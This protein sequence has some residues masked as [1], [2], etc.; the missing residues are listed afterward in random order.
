MTFTPTERRAAAEKIWPYREG[1]RREGYDEWI[2]TIETG[3]KDNVFSVAIEL[4]CDLTRAEGLLRRASGK[5]NS[6]RYEEF[7][8]EIVAF[9]SDTQGER[10]E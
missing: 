1:D 6:E 10:Q 7:Q 8:A 4:Q 9:L 5:I 2:A 3:Q